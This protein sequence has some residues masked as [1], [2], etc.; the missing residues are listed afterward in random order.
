MPGKK[1]GENCVSG[2]L[3]GVCDSKTVRHGCPKCLD[4]L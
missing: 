2:R 1:Q 4:M 3:W